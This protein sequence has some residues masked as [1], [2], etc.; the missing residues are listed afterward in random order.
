MKKLVVYLCVGVLA[1][2]LTACAAD[3]GDAPST[4]NQNTVETT[5]APTEEPAPTEAPEATEAPAEGGDDTT[6][7]GLA[8]IRETVIA[9]IGEENYFPNMEIPAEFFEGYGLTSDIVASFWGE[10]PMISTNVDT[11]VVVE[12]K[13]GQVDAVETALNGYR[14][15]LV[16]DSMQYPMNVGKVQASMIETFGNYVCFVQLGGDVD[17][18]FMDEGTDEAVIKHCQAQNELAIEAIGKVLGQ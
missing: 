11:V 16:N 6:A 15:Y 1:L 9:A 13:E 18:V 10:M 4:D 12:A 7:S 8:D 14:D 5:P 3:N 17:S 2:G